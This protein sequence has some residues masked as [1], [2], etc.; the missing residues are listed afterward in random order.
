MNMQIFMEIVYELLVIHLSI[1]V[2]YGLKHIFIVI[3]LTSLR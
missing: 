1:Y 2:L 3:E